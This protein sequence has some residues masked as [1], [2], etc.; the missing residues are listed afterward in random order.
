MGDR[1]VD[2][3]HSRRG[4]GAEGE[5]GDGGRRFVASEPV[6]KGG[7]DGQGARIPVVLPESWKLRIARVR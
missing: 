2:L 4:E 6:E 3:G 7:E 5:T 1:G